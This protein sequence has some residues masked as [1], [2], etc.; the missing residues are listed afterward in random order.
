MISREADPAAPIDPGV[1]DER[2]IVL[3]LFTQNVVFPEQKYAWPVPDIE[4]KKKKKQN[5]RRRERKSYVVKSNGRDNVLGNACCF[6][7]W[8]PG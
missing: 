3:F 8:M 7:A 5:A 2:R 4:K 1:K 6:T